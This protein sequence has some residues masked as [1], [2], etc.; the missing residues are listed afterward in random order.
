MGS[1]ARKELEALIASLLDVQED[2]CAPTGNPLPLP[3]PG[4]L[5]RPSTRR[6]FDRT[7][8]DDHYKARNLQIVCRF[9]NFWKG[10]A[11]NDEF[12]NLLLLARGGGM[13]SRSRRALKT[14]RSHSSYAHAI[15]CHFPKL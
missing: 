2:R 13:G 10:A 9:V 1:R 6:S 3:W 11:D 12:R 14:S 7:D 4:L 15:S 8:S 5:T